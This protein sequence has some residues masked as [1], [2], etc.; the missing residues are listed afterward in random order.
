MEVSEG[1]VSAVKSGSSMPES[2]VDTIA[3]EPF[4]GQ[5]KEALKDVAFGSIS[6]IVGKFIEYPFDT[7]KVRLQSQP[8]RLPPLY[9]GPLD[10][11]KQALRRDGFVGLYRGISAPLVGAAVETSGLFFSVRDQRSKS[12]QFEPPLIW[13]LVSARS[14]CPEGNHAPANSRLIYV[15]TA[16]LRCCVRRFHVLASDTNRAC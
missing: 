2:V 15:G 11:F 13:N 7:V 6:G 16:V 5:G 3:R 10:C 4:S 12:L 8:D 14:G 9:T 1:P